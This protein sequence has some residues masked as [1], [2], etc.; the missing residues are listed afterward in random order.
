MAC[1]VTPDLFTYKP[2]LHKFELSSRQKA[3]RLV[4]PSSRYPVHFSE[5]APWRLIGKNTI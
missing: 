1:R 3:S 2:H 4:E 5:L